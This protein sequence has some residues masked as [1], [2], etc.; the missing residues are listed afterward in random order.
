MRKSKEK[1]DN[2]PRAVLIGNGSGGGMGEVLQQQQ[3]WW[4]C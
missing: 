2:V 4:E 1:N 3:W